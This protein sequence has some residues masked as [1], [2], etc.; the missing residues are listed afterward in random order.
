MLSEVW[1]VP[2]W[3][4]AVSTAC[5]RPLLRRGI[6]LIMRNPYYRSI[7]NRVVDRIMF[8]HDDTET[9]V[10]FLRSPD[11][12]GIVKD[13]CNVARH[14]ESFLYT[15]ARYR[16]VRQC[17]K[18]VQPD[19]EQGRLPTLRER[20]RSS[21]TELEDKTR[22]VIEA[23]GILILLRAL[24]A[25]VTTAVI[26][27]QSLI[28]KE[29]LDTYH[30]LVNAMARFANSGIWVSINQAMNM[31]FLV[32]SFRYPSLSCTPARAIVVTVWWI[33]FI[34]I[35]LALLVY[36]PYTLLLSLMIVPTI[37]A[38]ERIES[39][40][41]LGTALFSASDKCIGGY[42]LYVLDETP[43]PLAYSAITA[44][45]IPSI[46]WIGSSFDGWWEHATYDFYRR[47]GFMVPTDMVSIFQLLSSL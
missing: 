12:V 34:P 26:V 6:L 27:Y 23:D 14:H 16:T 47:M 31:T 33:I 22:Q 7:V 44:G 40:P 25:L 19:L 46:C 5:L 28:E 37:L 24:L 1:I 42:H 45:L 3:M 43:Q 2:L 15:Y 38:V 29:T 30:V 13:Y 4:V 21:P 32:T 20:Y 11:V 10:S 39:L 41:Y 36:V 17:I 35:L 8:H 9:L 18:G